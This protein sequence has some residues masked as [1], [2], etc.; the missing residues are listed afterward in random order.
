MTVAKTAPQ[1]VARSIREDGAV[2]LTSRHTLGP[3]AETTGAWLHDWAAQTPAAVF[4]AERS[5]AG[6]R[7]VTYAEALEQVQALAAWL[8]DQPEQ[9]LVMMISGNSID[10]GLLALAAQ[11]VG[12]ANV[13]VAEQYSLIPGAQDRLIHIVRKLRPALIYVDD[14]A[15]YA[16]ALALPELADIPVL[17]S[18]P[19]GAPRA[20]MPM[21]RA[22]T[23]GTGDVATAHAR[24]TPDTVGKILFTSGSTDHPKGVLTTHRMMCVNQT[25][26]ADA[27][28]VLR[29][30]RPRI[31]DWLPWNH[32][33]GGSHNFNMMLAHGGALYIDDG[34][35]TEA[36]FA[37]TLENLSMHTGT[38]S[39]NVPVGYARLVSALRADAGLRRR[40]FEGLHFTFYAGASLPQEIWDALGDMARAVTGEV[41]LMV[42]SW[43]MTETAPA[44][45]L[46]HERIDQS[47]IVGAPVAGTTVK[48]IP[49]DES[50]FELRVKGPNVMPGY[51]ED[52][53]KTRAAFDAEGFLITGDAVRFVNED[54]PDRGLR[55][56]GRISEDFK[57]SSGT[58]VRVAALRGR[59]MT[60]LEG[61]AADIVIT[62]HD[63]ADLGVLI[64]PAATVA[65]DGA[66]VGPVLMQSVANRL[67]PLA[68]NATGSSTRVCRALILSEPP[69]LEAQEMTA[70]GNLNTRR[71]LTRRAGLVARLHDDTDPAVIRV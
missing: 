71:V 5:G 41:P 27:F 59:L 53:D 8:L 19:E 13:P 64:F 44:V 42:S 10:H 51:F 43:G 49:E 21:A 33:F 70:K 45:L 58:W 40:F 47:G 6:W 11:Y 63:R 3:V 52:D 29:S 12:R 66:C 1:S 35:P 57:L 50:R 31:L 30:E 17:A 24:V 56:D 22:L 9:G 61:L 46:T 55:F 48:L 23:G 60:A 7:E 25:Q 28:P 16:K 68:A 18:R 4:L 36:L 20:V 34:K 2:L 67:G 14:A 62:G 65:G 54:A 15:R 32:V 39:F 37:R 26:L 38:L 69:S